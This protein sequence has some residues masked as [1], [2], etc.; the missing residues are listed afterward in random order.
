MP[1]QVRQFGPECLEQYAGIPIRFTVESVLHVEAVEDGLG[2]LRLSEQNVPEPYVKD[3]DAF[4]GERAT[5]W[6]RR[7]DVSNWGF[8]IAFDGDRPVGAA[9][10]ALR[11]PGVNMLRGRNDLA[12]LWD[13]RVAPQRRR[14]G[15]GSALWQ[16]AIQFAREQGCRELRV[17]TQNINV[18]ACRFYAAQG[19]RLLQIDRAGYQGAAG[20]EDEAMLIWSLQL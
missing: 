4:E 19:S 18:A 11:T 16:Q 10:V 9:A 15:A 14:Q 2:G 12:A 6:P 13:I 20:C 1:V 8:F 3:Y 17:E 5:E 7:F